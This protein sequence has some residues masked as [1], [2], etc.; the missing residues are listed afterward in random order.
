MY[1]DEP[2]MNHEWDRAMYEYNLNWD[3]SLTEKRKFVRGM[4]NQ[5][6]EVTQ[7]M[8]DELFNI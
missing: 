8:P 3:G 6:V 1:P 5:T 4:D 7:H 2:K